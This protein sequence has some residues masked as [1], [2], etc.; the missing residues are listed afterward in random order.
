MTTHSTNRPAEESGTFALGGDLAV[1][2]LGYGS[3]QLT[4]P[5]NWGSPRTGTGPSPCSVA[6]SIW[7]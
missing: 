6:P 4:G 7:G 3:M 5:T 1:H 2:R